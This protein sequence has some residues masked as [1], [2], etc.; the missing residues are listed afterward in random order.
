MLFNVTKAANYTLDER[1]GRY[2]RAIKL[3]EL[4]VAIHFANCFPKKVKMATSVDNAALSDLIV[5]LSTKTLHDA[6]ILATIK[7]LEHISKPIKDEKGKLSAKTLAQNPDWAKLF[8][9]FLRFGGFRRARHVSAAKQ[10][11]AEVQKAKRKAR[12]LA[13]AIDFSL[14]FE[15]D[16]KK[17][18]QIGGITMARD[19]VANSEYFNVKCSEQTLVNYWKY[20]EPV[21][22][23]LPLIYL[24]KYPA[25]PLRVSGT[26][27]ADKLLSRIDDR[28]TLNEF[29]A[30]YNANVLRLKGRGYELRSLVGLPTAQ[31]TFDALPAEVKT[32]VECYRR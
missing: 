17:P 1:K 27:F 10:F 24:K 23:F 21:A 22:A 14:R 3:F 30:E 7:L 31:I 20:F 4:H 28:K 5:G 8:A 26:K 25:W 9:K 12:K 11:D 19:I 32:L 6:R 15:Q 16:T 29:F 18:K 2:S 13:K